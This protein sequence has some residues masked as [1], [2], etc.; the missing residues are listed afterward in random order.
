MLIPIIPTFVRSFQPAF[1][2]NLAGDAGGSTTQTNVVKIL[3]AALSV[4]GTRVKIRV[5]SGQTAALS[6]TA[7]YIGLSATTGSAWNFA[8]AATQIT[9]GGVGTLT[10]GAQQEIESD[11]VDFVVDKSAAISIAF[12]VSANSR[13]AF[14]TSVGGNFIRY[15]LNSV[16]EA[17]STTKT[18]GYSNTGSR[19]D[20]IESLILA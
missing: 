1:N 14:S 12:S 20:L 3:P 4:T 6:L 11:A 5:R 16:S 17:S 18:A 15:F 2:I 19:L 10:L 8:A 7:C 9:F 13:H